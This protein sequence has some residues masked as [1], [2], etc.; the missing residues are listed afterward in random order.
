MLMA[1]GPRMVSMF[2]G[3]KIA[4]RANPNIILRTIGKFLAPRKGAR[5]IRGKI[6]AKVKKKTESA[7]VG[8]R[9]GSDSMR[10]R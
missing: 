7:V 8:S 6:R 5:V 1:R 2:C 3:K 9:L 4:T 10:L